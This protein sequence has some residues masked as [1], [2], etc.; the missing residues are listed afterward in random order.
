MS[1]SG[2]AAQARIAEK[3]TILNDRGLGLLTRLYDMKKTLSNPDTRPSVFTE[4]GLESVIKAM[5]GKRFNPNSGNSQQWGN[6]VNSNI[7]QNILKSLQQHYFTMVDM[8]EF[9]DNVGELFVII[10]ANQIHFDISLN[11]DLT[12]RYLDLVVTYV[13]MMIMV[14]RIEDRR[15]LLGLYNI[16]HELQ[17]NH[18]ESSFPRLAQMMIDYQEAPVKKMCEEFTPHVKCLTY[19]LLSLKVMHI[20]RSTSVFLVFIT[21]SQCMK[22]RVLLHNDILF[23]I[24]R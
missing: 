3:L 23:I 10:D 12:K 11:F 14:S 21:V 17:H 16:A 2:Q 4:K 5:D 15:A 1:R 18:Q 7:K 6:V 20:T 22:A 24:R 19:A 9:K 13:S 8:I